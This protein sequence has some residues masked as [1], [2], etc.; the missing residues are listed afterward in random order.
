ME[1][2]WSIK[3]YQLQSNEDILNLDTEYKIIITNRNSGKNS[4][5]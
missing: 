4:T 5:A 2:I 1:I 3:D